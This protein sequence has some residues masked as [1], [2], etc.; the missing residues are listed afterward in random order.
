MTDK[1]LVHVTCPTRAVA[2]SIAAALIAQRLAACVSIAAPLTS[3]YRWRGAVE[4]AEEHPLTIKTR[5]DLF[6]RVCAAVRE[7]HN[8]ETPEIIASPL[9]D[10][11]ADYLD[12]IDEELVP[13]ED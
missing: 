4:R 13:R 7:L 9:I 1:I 2:D 3:L 12:W 6:A 8:Y 10:G 11:A 5:R